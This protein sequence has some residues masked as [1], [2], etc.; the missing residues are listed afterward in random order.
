[1]SVH[2]HG[3]FALGYNIT[4]LAKKRNRPSRI[5]SPFHLKLS[6]QARLSF[7]IFKVEASIQKSDLISQSIKAPKVANMYTQK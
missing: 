1:M 5:M 3:D 7:C 4:I 6:I 2:D